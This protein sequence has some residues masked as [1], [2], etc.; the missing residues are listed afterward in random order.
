M[1]KNLGPVNCL[2]PMPV[3]IVGS[4]TDGRVNYMPVAH[5][6]IM[7]HD[8]QS[9]IS[10]SMAKI[11]YTTAGVKQ[12]KVFSV[13]LPSQDLV[14]QTD[15]CGLVS[16][17]DIDKSDVF[18][19]FYGELE[20]APMIVECP[21]NMECR[22][23]QLVDFKTHDILIGEIISAHADESILTNGTIDMDKL[24][25]MLFDMGRKEYFKLGESFAKCWGVGMNY[26]K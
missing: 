20:T 4:I 14:V 8:L 5:V 9:Y 17:H 18:E 22:L 7:N 24:K 11:H 25:P 16:G 19:T 15:Y 21:V 10:V 3:T 26:K 13:N 23:Y 2:Y 12:N 6:G 1:K